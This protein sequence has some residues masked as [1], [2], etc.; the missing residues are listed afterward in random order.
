M[1]K[2]RLLMLLGVV[3]LALVLAAMPF[4][5]ACA[6]PAPAPAP[7][8]A[9]APPPAPPKAVEWRMNCGPE[10]A[11]GYGVGTGM[12]VLLNKEIEG[13]T[14][15][16]IGGGT[17]AAARLLSGGE[18]EAQYM[19]TFVIVDAWQDRGAFAE[20]PLKVKAYQGVWFWTTAII[21]F[22]REGTGIKSYDDLAG[23]K[24]TIGDPK[25]GLFPPQV[26][27]YTALGLWD[28]MDNKLIA[29]DDLPDALKTGVVDA[30]LGAI[31]ANASPS[32]FLRKID[33]HNRDLWGL[34]MTKEQQEIIDKTPGLTFTWAKVA[35]GFTQDIG[36]EEIPGIGVMYGWAFHP[37]TDPDL[38]YQFVKTCFE[39]QKSLLEI[40]PMFGPWSEDA[41]GFSKKALGA[42][43]GVPIHPG[44]AKYYKEIGI[45]EATWV[46]GK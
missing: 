1:K 31:M 15:L 26:A 35:G 32:S 34:T 19:N 42:A 12:S 14:L 11:A 44:A 37:S 45:W 17:V 6:K 4:M 30:S 29:G 40:S 38:V 25:W 22:T 46:E 39:N 41:K 23:R 27:G 43:P 33:L 24:V 20:E 8:P 36:M 7:T 2:K 3:S 10:A 9:P 16:P 21:M 28:K 5:A 18:L 13:L